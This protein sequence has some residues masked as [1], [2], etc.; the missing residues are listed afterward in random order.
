MTTAACAGARAPA[1][2]TRRAAPPRCRPGSPRLARSRRPGLPSA[3]R[4][5]RAAAARSLDPAR[6]VVE[7]HAVHGGGGEVVLDPLGDRAAVVATGPSGS[8]THAP[9]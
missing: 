6:E 3:R 9:T 4:V 8:A 2:T 5:S 1:P 7:G